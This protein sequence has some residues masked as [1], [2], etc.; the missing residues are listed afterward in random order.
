M[1][2]LFALIAFFLLSC[3]NKQDGSPFFAN[4]TQTK[5]Y[6]QPFS[7]LPSTYTSYV[8]SELKK[9]YPDI[10]LLKPVSLPQQSWYKPRNRYRADS[11]IY[12]L[13]NKAKN[14]E[15]IIGL[16]SKDIST[17][18]N[19]IKDFGVMGLGFTPGKACVISTFRL[20]KQNL[21]QQFFKVSIHELGHTQGLNHCPVKTCFMRD[22]EGGNPTDEEKELC[23]LCKEQLI[24]KGWIL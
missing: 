6:I 1:R 4:K 5:I 20:N 18:K 8:V 11:L 17:T 9:F 21:K 10:T 3:H 2:W 12:W 15:V 24:R 23:I 13:K 16:T 19:E 22:A 7:D 14:G